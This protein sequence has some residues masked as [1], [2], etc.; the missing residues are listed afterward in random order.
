MI[1]K[2]LMIILIAVGSVNVYAQKSVQESSGDFYQI[3]IYHLKSKAQEDLMDNYLKNAYLPA[4]HKLGIQHVGVFKPVKDSA[5]TK[6]YDATIYVFIPFPNA[7]AFFQLDKK[8]NADKEYLDKAESYINANYDAIPYERYESILLN[9]FPQSLHYKLPMLKGPKK[10]RVYEL[11]SYEGPTEKYFRN[12][13]SMFNEGNEVSIF[14]RLNF[15]AVFYASVVSGSHMP[16]LM[17]LT[18]FEN[19]QDRE[20]HWKAFSNDNEWKTLLAQPKYAHNV[21]H[22]DILFLFP[23]DYSDI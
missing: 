3:K 12:K 1:N 20:E 13:V 11:R 22:A 23:A 7:N 8:L 14:K 5:D 15:N 19:K 16:N 9:A 21:S 18:T 2:L 10:D 6:N 17:Y 4:L